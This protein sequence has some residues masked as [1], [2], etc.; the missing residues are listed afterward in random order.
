M[1]GL[2]VQ[3]PQCRRVMHT[4]TDFYD[5]SKTAKGNMV[6]LLPK[7]AKRGWKTFFYGGGST[8]PAASMQCPHCSGNLAPSGKL[9]IRPKAVLPLTPEELFEQYEPHAPESTKPVRSQDQIHTCSLCGKQ[10]KGAAPFAMH[11]KKC[12]RLHND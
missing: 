10:V 2:D 6:K 4:T 7:W 11:L 9:R 3:C 8:T 5:P 1:I 12:Q